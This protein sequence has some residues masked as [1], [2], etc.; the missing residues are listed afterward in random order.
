MSVDDGNDA[1]PIAPPHRDNGAAEDSVEHNVHE[2]REDD[3]DIVPAP[4]STGHGEPS[5]KD[6]PPLTVAPRSKAVSDRGGSGSGAQDIPPFDSD[7][8]RSTLPTDGAR[9]GRI[10][11]A[12]V[13]DTSAEIAASSARHSL[14]HSLPA[15]GAEGGDTDQSRSLV[16]DSTGRNATISS[17]VLAFT[18]PGTSS[19][20]IGGSADDPHVA[21]DV[22]EHEGGGSMSAVG[23]SADAV[24]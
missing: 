17:P 11:D 3:S 7:E 9:P 16:D 21:I 23:E 19:A 13:I 1:A 12:V 22:D 5:E 20:T 14:R 6:T 15:A 24:G 18:E 10:V 2:I 8:D 4:I